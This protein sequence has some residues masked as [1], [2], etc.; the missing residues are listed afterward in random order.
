MWQVQQHDV[1]GGALHEG[2]HGRVAVLADDEVT[3][4]VPRYG[5]VGH[6]G[7]T[8]GDHH[9][10]GDLPAPNNS[11]TRAA[12]GPP[13]SQAARQLASQLTP[14]L[15]VDGLVDRLVRHPHHGLV[16]K[17]DAEPLGDLLW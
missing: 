15:H 16:G 11:R 17:L 2:A 10:V 8:I 7:R 13:R 1:A 3:L 9:H 5:P 14:A 4:P 12:L 6:L